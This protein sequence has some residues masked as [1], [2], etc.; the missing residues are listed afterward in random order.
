MS[1]EFRIRSG[2]ATCVTRRPLAQFAVEDE[3]A[4]RGLAHHLQLLDDRFDLGLF[5][6]LLGDEPLEEGLGGEIALGLGQLDQAVDQAGDLALVL[7]GVLEDLQHGAP[8]GLGG[9]DRLEAD[10]SGAG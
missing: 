5:L 2:R 4:D 1:E 10:A 7:V 6:D 9:V 8:F 3:Q